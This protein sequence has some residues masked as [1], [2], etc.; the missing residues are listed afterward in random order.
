LAS[1]IH[2]TDSN[3]S[4]NAPVADRR[5]IGL[6][7]MRAAE[8]AL[9]DPENSTKKTRFCMILSILN[10]AIN[11]EDKPRGPNVFRRVNGVKLTHFRAAKTSTDQRLN[12]SSPHPRPMNNDSREGKQSFEPSFDEM[13]KILAIPSR[14]KRIK[15]L[16][17][18]RKLKRLSAQ[19]AGSAEE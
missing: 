16:R 19:P 5:L 17:L 18:C 2:T 10:H 6:R 7:A 8:K 4:V 1:T 3:G 13:Q 14:W 12:G 11:A 9:R 15:A